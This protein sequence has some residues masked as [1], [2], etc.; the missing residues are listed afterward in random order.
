[1]VPLQRKVTKRDA[2]AV[3][4]NTL[5]KTDTIL[6]WEGLNHPIFKEKPLKKKSLVYSAL[7]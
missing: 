5:K 3:I 7:L 6:G 1:M 2:E 4:W